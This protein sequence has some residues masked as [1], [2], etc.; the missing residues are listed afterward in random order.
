MRNFTIIYREIVQG[1]SHRRVPTKKHSTVQN[2]FKNTV[3]DASASHENPTPIHHGSH[4]T[5]MQYHWGTDADSSQ[6]INIRR[7]FQFESI[8]VMQFLSILS[9]YDIVVYN[10]AVWRAT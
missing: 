2:V 1:D 3:P 6:R 9:N 7:I 8:I 10:V 4:D 5:Q